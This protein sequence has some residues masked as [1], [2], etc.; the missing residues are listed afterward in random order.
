MSNG[1]RTTLTRA[2]LAAPVGIGLVWMISAFRWDSWVWVRQAGMTSIRSAR[3]QLE[4]DQ[5]EWPLLKTESRFEHR[6]GRLV[7]PFPQRKTRFGFGY[8]GGGTRDVQGYVVTVRYWAA[9]LISS[10][11]ALPRLWFWVRERRRQ[12]GGQFCV[13]CGYNLRGT[14]ER[15]PECGLAVVVLD[16]AI[17]DA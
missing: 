3:G 8:V 4:F 10:I 2:L 7:T 9:M 15:C 6:G 14:P 17:P 11:P 13:R 16:S 12:V 1:G 5:R